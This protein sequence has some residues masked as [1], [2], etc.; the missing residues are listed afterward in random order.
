M[1]R[2]VWSATSLP[3]PP[4]EPPRDHHLHP[5]LRPRLLAARPAASPTVLRKETVG[6]ALL[7]AGA[8]IAL[9]WA[10]S[11]WADAYE[12]LRDTRGRARRRCTWT[13]PSAPGPPTGC[14]RSSS[15]SPGLELK[16]EFVA[17][18]LREPRRAALPV[19]AAVG[20]MAVPALLF[21]LVNLGA[22]GRRP[23]RLGDPVGDRHRLRP[24]RPRGDQH[25]PA[26]RAAHLP[27]HPRR[28][29]RPA[30]DH[31]H[32]DLLHRGAL[33]RLPRAGAAAARGVRAC[34]CSGGSGRCVAAAPARGRSR[35][36]SCT[37][38]ACTRRS[39]GVLLA[40]TVPVCAAT[41]AARTRTGLAEHFEH[42]FRPL[43]AGVAVPV[44]AFFSAGVTVG[45]LSGLGA[46]L[47][48]S[49]ALGIVV[50]A[51]R[52][53]DDRHHRGHLA[54]LPLHPRPA[55]RA[56]SAG[57][58]SSVSRCSAASASPSRC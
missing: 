29:R 48:D 35:G 3:T 55:R 2:E 27:A 20:G 51:G 47:G 53:Q 21:V 23:A 46:S 26:H 7:L 1:R 33:G 4:P 56:T 37:P 30:G 13:C 15:S 25:P 9:V 40:F 6:G 28:R 14:W 38:P 57:P 8:V 42:R 5:P 34:S 32:R 19:A 24:R 58:T 50:G 41:P 12:T 16:R 10:N 43:S 49:V 45:G 39:P 18:D 44:F 11:P 31:D 52:R 22:G 36:R 17:G 54:G